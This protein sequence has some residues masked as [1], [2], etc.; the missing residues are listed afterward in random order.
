[1]RYLRKRI[2]TKMDK[3]LTPHAPPFAKLVEDVAQAKM[4]VELI[5]DDERDEA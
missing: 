3:E 2:D 5:P 1:M 4:S